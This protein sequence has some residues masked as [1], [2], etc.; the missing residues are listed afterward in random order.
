MR[1]VV[2]T[3]MSGAGKASAINMLEDQGFYCVDNL[4]VRLIDKFMELVNQ[5]GSGISK[6]VLGLEVRTDGTFAA[7]DCGLFVLEERR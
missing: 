1:F 2:V 5:P 3:G 4:P 7:V 6:V